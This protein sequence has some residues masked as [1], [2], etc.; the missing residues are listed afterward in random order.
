MATNQKL[1]TPLYNCE[2]EWD[3]YW[4]QPAN[5]RQGRPPKLSDFEEDSNTSRIPTKIMNCI[6]AEGPYKKLLEALHVSDH[7]QSD[8][9]R[10][11]V[12]SNQISD[13]RPSQQINSL[14]IPLIN[15]KDPQNL[16]N[17]WLKWT[18]IPSQIKM[19]AIYYSRWK[20]SIKS[21]SAKLQLHPQ[22]V[23]WIVNHFNKTVDEQSWLFKTTYPKHRRVVD[24]EQID[25]LTNYMSEHRHIRIT[26]TDVKQI[27]QKQ[28][29]FSFHASLSTIK[30][31]LKHK[32]HFSYK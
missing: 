1:T 29:P 20:W 7:D 30:R 5:R 23:K 21:I 6:K 8:L 14:E 22:L 15:H 16:F 31:L 4:D 17:R 13:V 27:M 19:Q 2:V 24:D 9:L 28:F 25:W 32:L 18:N 10:S 11:L 3:F 26:A 12:D